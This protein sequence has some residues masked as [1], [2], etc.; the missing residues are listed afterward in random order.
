MVD[1]LLCAKYILP[2]L[3][4]WYGKSISKVSINLNTRQS[5]QDA[6]ISKVGNTLKREDSSAGAVFGGTVM[7]VALYERLPNLHTLY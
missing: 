4:G 7:H 6:P 3:V 5:Q 2:L 1:F